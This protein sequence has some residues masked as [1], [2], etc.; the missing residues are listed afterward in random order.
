[1]G[2][3][4]QCRVIFAV[5]KDTRDLIQASC[6]NELQKGLVIHASLKGI[7]SKCPFNS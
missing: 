6:K 7:N 5:G 1:M 4:I 2:N 3:A